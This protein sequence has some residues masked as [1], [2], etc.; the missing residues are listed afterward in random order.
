MAVD[1]NNSISPAEHYVSHAGDVLNVRARFDGTIIETNQ[2]FR[3]TFGRSE[4]DQGRNLYELLKSVYDTSVPFLSNC[5]SA[6]GIPLVLLHRDSEQKFLFY[7]YA[8]HDEITLLGASDSLPET[9]TAELLSSLTA[10]LGNMVR[11]VHRLNREQSKVNESNLQLAQIDGL[12]GL[13]NHNT[14]LERGAS[15]VSNASSQGIPLSLVMMDLDHFKLVNDKFGH[16]QG[17]HVLSVLGEL[18]ISITREGDVAARYGGEEFVVLLPNTRID[19]AVRFA[20]RTRAAMQASLPVGQS[21]S[22]T[23]SL[24]VAQ[25]RKAETLTALIKRADDALYTAKNGGRNRVCVAAD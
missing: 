19:A 1:I 14:L 11:D 5:E 23:L 9:K 2:A 3:K 20:E 4:S 12:T 22:V 8:V 21:H 10:E 16:Q 24:G 18:L 13:C 25:L 17:D 7:L 15:L 6:F